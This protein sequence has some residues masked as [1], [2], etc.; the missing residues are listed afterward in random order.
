MVKKEPVAAADLAIEDVPNIKTRKNILVLQKRF[1]QYD[2]RKCLEAL[3]E[4]E[5]DLSDAYYTLVDRNAK[6]KE[7]AE[8]RM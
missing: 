5:Y 6:E 4:N 8:A 7:D 3:T 1:P 2:V